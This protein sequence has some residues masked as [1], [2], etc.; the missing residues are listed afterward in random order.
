MYVCHLC[1]SIFRADA[2]THLKPKTFWLLRRRPRL[3]H[4]CKKYENLLEATE[5]REVVFL[6]K[7]GNSRPLFRICSVF[8]N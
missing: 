5:V 6:K 7:M 1:T 8:S 3:A 4:I 2:H